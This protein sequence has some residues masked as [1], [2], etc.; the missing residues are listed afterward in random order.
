MKKR[1]RTV[2][3]VAGVIL[4]LAFGIGAFVYL[5]H[6]TVSA[7]GNN[8][9][10]LCKEETVWYFRTEN[11]V[12]QKRQWS[13]TYGKWLTDWTEVAGVTPAVSSGPTKDNNPANILTKT[14]EEIKNEAYANLKLNPSEYKGEFLLQ[15]DSEAILMVYPKDM[16]VLAEMPV[17]SLSMKED[18]FVYL[19]FV[20]REKEKL[21]FA[22]SKETML[23]QVGVYEVNNNNCIG[24][25]YLENFR[26]WE[27]YGMKWVYFDDAQKLCRI[28]TEEEKRESLCEY[29]KERKPVLNADGTIT[30]YQ[31][32]GKDACMEKYL[33]LLQLDIH[34]TAGNAPEYFWKKEK[35]SDIANHYFYQSNDYSFLYGITAAEARILFNGSEYRSDDPDRVKN[36]AITEVFFSGDDLYFTV[37]ENK[38]E[39]SSYRIY[40]IGNNKDIS[41]FWEFT[42]D[43]LKM[44]HF[45]GDQ[46]NEYENYVANDY[47]ILQMNVEKN[48]KTEEEKQVFRLNQNSMMRTFSRIDSEEKYEKMADT[49]K[50]P[51]SKEYF[52]S[53]VFILYI[54]ENIDKDR[55]GFLSET[56]R[57]SVESIDC[58][59]GIIRLYRSKQNT[60]TS[61]IFVADG[62]N[63]FPNL[64]NISINTY[65]TYE[66]YLENHSG[67]QS[68]SSCEQHY[69]FHFADRCENLEN[70]W[71]C[72]AYHLYL[73]IDQCPKLEKIGGYEYGLSG[74][75]VSN[76]PN[77]IYR[78]D[79]TIGID[80]LGFLDANARIVFD[81]TYKNIQGV[82]YIVDDDGY[83]KMKNTRFL[84]RIC[85]IDSVHPEYD[86]AERIKT[87]EEMQKTAANQRKEEGSAVL[88]S[89]VLLFYG[90]KQTCVFH[91]ASRQTGPEEKELLT[92]YCVLEKDG[93]VS[94]Y[95]S[96]EEL[97]A[98]AENIQ[99]LQNFGKSFSAW[100]Y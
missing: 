24:M 48:G 41:L 14:A 5:G 55:D 54:Q 25:V 91:F 4:I 57:E 82:P 50:L 16:K 77:F 89:S 34:P 30:I 29:W 66:V 9:T 51:I 60:N 64:K 65:G 72:T 18:E 53:P 6:N 95:E 99:G 1:K 38:N 69:G 97:L 62:L 94:W 67:I 12:T 73:Y 98:A 39:E 81:E 11:G 78:Y 93:S 7:M 21:V 70:T 19:V 35:T 68:F 28:C 84:N 96:R 74:L 40:N 13:Y 86:M 2:F 23:S 43:R 45:H 58:D 92:R 10:L 44:T 8:D 17:A 20:R 83:V 33:S 15:T 52:S 56:E 31:R 22:S 32:A 80:Y 88:T 59:D 27:R 100:K 42:G 26:G 61:E 3:F 75:Y 71:F 79:E 87:M 90:P 85:W 49:E 46:G 47:F 36:T 63:W 37:Y 76:S